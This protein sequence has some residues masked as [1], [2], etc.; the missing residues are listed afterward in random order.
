VSAE[1]RQKLQLLVTDL[2]KQEAN[3]ITLLQKVLVSM[4]LLFLKEKHGKV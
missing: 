1:Q 4:P 3:Y 2:K